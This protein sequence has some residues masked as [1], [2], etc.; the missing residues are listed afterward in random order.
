MSYKLAISNEMNNLFL[1]DIKGGKNL[2]LERISTIK[3]VTALKL[4]SCLNVVQ[5]E[6][7]KIESLHNTLRVR[8]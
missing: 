3:R 6:T 1:D 5:N 8:S 2:K 4:G 7:V